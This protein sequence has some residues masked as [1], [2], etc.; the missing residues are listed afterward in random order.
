MSTKPLYDLGKDVARDMLNSA[1][2]PLKIAA[3]SSVFLLCASEQSALSAD[4]TPIEQDM[5]IDTSPPKAS[6]FTVYRA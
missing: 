5:K 2:R 1:M 6:D 4:P 3:L